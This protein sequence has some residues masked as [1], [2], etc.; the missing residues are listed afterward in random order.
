MTTNVDAQNP[1]VWVEEWHVDY[2]TKFKEINKKINELVDD[3]NK[4]D[5][6][7]KI[8]LANL[9][10]WNFVA[11]LNDYFGQN[12]N[13]FESFIN[14]LWETIQK[15][16]AKFEKDNA[17]KIPKE[18]NSLINFIDQVW[19]ELSNTN[20]TNTDFTK[21]KET[22]QIKKPEEPNKLEFNWQLDWVDEWEEW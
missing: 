6:Q 1:V 13:Q 10:D 2:D 17:W 16:V 20:L 7:A 9:I 19:S 15:I 5:N 21:S 22:S 14:A 3:N 11:W 18:Y 8:D 12:P 4:N